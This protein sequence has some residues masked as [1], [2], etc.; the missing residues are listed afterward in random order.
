MS[1]RTMRYVGGISAGIIAGMAFAAFSGK[2]M[3]PGKRFRRGRNKA[4]H[5]VTDMIDDVGNMVR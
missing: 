2:M 1:R 5:A 4:F 3:K